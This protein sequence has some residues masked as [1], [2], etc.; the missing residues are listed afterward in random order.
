[1]SPPTLSERL[2]QQFYAWELQ[3]RGL[4][5][6]AYPVELEPP[7][8]PFPGYALP[9]VED[10]G[11]RPGLLGRLFP[12]PPRPVA[13]PEVH[14]PEP[15][16]FFAEE[17]LVE[18]RVSLPAGERFGADTAERF[19]LSLAGAEYPM[20]FELVAHAERLAVQIAVRAPDAAILGSELRAFFPEVSAVAEGGIA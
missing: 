2:T 5:E 7:F 8:R 20:A 17:P 18:F 4:E 11:H 12:P 10:D 15:R 19:L 3:G 16:P 9:R 1:M 6:F 13:P 14:E